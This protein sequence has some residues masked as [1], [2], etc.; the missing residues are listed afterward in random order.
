MEGKSGPGEYHFEVYEENFYING[1]ELILPG[2]SPN[3]VPL[4]CCFDEVTEWQVEDR[5]FVLIK[6]SEFARGTKAAY[7][8]FLDGEDVNTGEKLWDVLRSREMSVISYLVVLMCSMIFL[9]T[10]LLIFCD[11]EQPVSIAGAATLMLI[12]LFLWISTQD[13][14]KRDVL[15]ISVFIISFLVATVTFFYK[16][17]GTKTN[18]A[19]VAL[20]VLQGILWMLI[21]KVFYQGKRK[22]L[23]LH[24]QVST[25]S[26]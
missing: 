1:Q 16:L 11:M 22:V 23:D 10:I 21:L 17:F 6:S 13:E 5:N 3:S 19:E 12:C 20:M 14:N 4:L 9:G 26:V 15:L 2:R 18:F 8:L 7:R 24:S 25:H